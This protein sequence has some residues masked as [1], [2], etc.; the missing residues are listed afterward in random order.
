MTNKNNL[1]SGEIHGKEKGGEDMN[2][3]KAEAIVDKLMKNVEGLRWGS[4]CVLV[5]I[6]DGRIVGV[7]HSTTENRQ[8]PELTAKK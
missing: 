8:D 1:Q 7:T 4:A 6:H 5:K 2:H 3:I